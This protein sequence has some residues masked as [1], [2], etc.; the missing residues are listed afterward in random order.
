MKSLVVLMSLFFFSINA[1]ADIGKSNKID[2]ILALSGNKKINEDLEKMIDT[3]S[4]NLDSKIP[5]E[6][7]DAIA[8]VFRE[9]FSA[10]ELNKRMV[11]ALEGHYST[12]DIEE[13]YSFYNI[14]D[15]KRVSKL[16]EESF[17]PGTERS[18]EDYFKSL[19]SNPP[20]KERI[21]IIMNFFNQARFTEQSVDIVVAVQ[22][23]LASALGKNF[24]ADELK[25]L[26][27]NL[28]PQM[29]QVNLANALFTYKDLSNDE[30][31][32]YYEKVASNSRIMKM[33]NIYIT[34]LRNYTT[35]WAS[36]VGKAIQDEKM[37]LMNKQKK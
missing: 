2:S 11:N 30:L 3:Q 36:H 21:N 19:R 1:I 33:G 32:R 17:G 28:T 12:T 23:A 26:R 35:Q 27:T 34:E 8:K 4:R 25:A 15:I 10:K 31:K 24:S 5:S 9:N 13:M 22:I 20:S 16:E 18:R 29:E 14:P 37:A 6:S 7:R